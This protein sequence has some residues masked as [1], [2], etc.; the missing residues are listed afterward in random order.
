MQP[1]ASSTSPHLPP[2]LTNEAF[3]SS[4]TNVSQCRIHV[5]FF[6]HCACCTVSQNLALFCKE[7]L[8]VCYGRA[9]VMVGCVFQRSEKDMSVDR[10]SCTDCQVAANSLNVNGTPEV[11]EQRQQQGTDLTSTSASTGDSINAQALVTNQQAPCSSSCNDVPAQ[12]IVKDLTTSSDLGLS[13]SDNTS[14]ANKIRSPAHAQLLH[15]NE[16]VTVTSTSTRQRVIDEAIKSAIRHK[17][18]KP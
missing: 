8:L 6:T 13:V 2:S 10:P 3:V 11:V 9:S 15:D 4:I 5:Q 7:R 17:G 16:N 12:E 18:L 14:Q 1:V